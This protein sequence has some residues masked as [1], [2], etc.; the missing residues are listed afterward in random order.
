MGLAGRVW[1]DAR[2]N[3]FWGVIFRM[4]IKNRSRKCEFQ[5]QVG[6]GFWGFERPGCENR[7]GVVVGNGIIYNCLCNELY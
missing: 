6:V 1:Q 3:I 7:K 5:L 2:F 4:R